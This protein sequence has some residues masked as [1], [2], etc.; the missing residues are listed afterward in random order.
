LPALRLAVLLGGLLSVPAHADCPVSIGGSGFDDALSQHV[1][2]EL[3][4]ELEHLKM[5]Q[6]STTFRVALRWETG[7]DVV[8]QVSGAGRELKRQVS[9]ADIPLDGLPLTLAAV[10]AD[11]LNAFEKPVPAPPVAEAAEETPSAPKPAPTWRLSARLAGETWS[12]GQLQGGGDL[13]LRWA[14]S[15]I[16]FE[17]AA[18][19][20]AALTKTFAAGSVGSTSALGS[21]SVLPGIVRGPNLEIF[22][23]VAICAGAIWFSGMAATGFTSQSRSAALVSAR[24][25]LEVALL[26]GHALFSLRGGIDVPLHGVSATDGAQPLVAISGVGGYLTLG[27]G[28]GW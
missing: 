27:G 1:Q 28:L 15:R 26:L 6:G 24:A 17:L 3:D 12:G 21:F 14:P 7:G 16:A 20:R 9:V 5:C 19:G 22:G 10:S 13:A 11:L 25:G 8:V 4:V 18:G 23:E 2:R